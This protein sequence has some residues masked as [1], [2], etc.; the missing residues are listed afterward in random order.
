MIHQSFLAVPKNSN[1]AVL[2]TRKK[3]FDS[4][5]EAKDYLKDFSNQ[6]I[7][8]SSV[9]HDA[10]MT[11]ET[12]PEELCVVELDMGSVSGEFDPAELKVLSEKAV[13]DVYEKLKDDAPESDEN[14]ESEIKITSIEEIIDTQLRDKFAAAALCGIV[15]RPDLHSHPALL[16]HESFTLYA[17]KKAYKFADAMVKER[18]KE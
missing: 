12:E 18:E 4:L 2:R 5:A 11:P 15:S 8:H 16:D 1:G 6:S 14:S 17:A 7:I 9:C 3:V 13:R 10:P